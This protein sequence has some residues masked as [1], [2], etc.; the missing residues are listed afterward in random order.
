MT[1]APKPDP[2]YSVHRRNLLVVVFI[3]VLVLTP[4]SSLIWWVIQFFGW[5]G[6]AQYYIIGMLGLGLV[7]TQLCVGIAGVVVLLIGDK[8]KKR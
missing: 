7:A 2:D 6:D 8:E 4:L 3:G 1:F 5:F